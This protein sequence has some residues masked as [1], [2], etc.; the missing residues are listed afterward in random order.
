MNQF[1]SEPSMSV[2]PHRSYTPLSPLLYRRCI[3]PI[4]C[5]RSMGSHIYLCQP[6][7]RPI[8]GKS[9]WYSGGLSIGP[10]AATAIH[11]VCC[12]EKIAAVWHGCAVIVSC[13]ETESDSGFCLDVTTG[14]AVYLLKYVGYLLGVSAILCCQIL[15]PESTNN[16]E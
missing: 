4:F 14:H 3:I 5:T 2:I 13:Q 12:I 1:S 9:R 6:Q 10:Q 16:L 11:L 7:I 15:V 8:D